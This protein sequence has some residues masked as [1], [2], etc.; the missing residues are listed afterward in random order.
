MASNAG[1]ASEGGATGPRLGSID[2]ISLLG[3]DALRTL[4]ERVN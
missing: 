3:E 4:R 1:E 2:E